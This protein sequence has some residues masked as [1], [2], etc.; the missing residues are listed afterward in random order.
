MCTVSLLVPQEQRIAAEQPRTVSI[1]RAAS[2]VIPHQEICSG[3]D[4]G[5]RLST[6]GAPDASVVGEMRGEYLCSAVHAVTYPS[7]SGT[8]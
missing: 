8:A 3:S 5:E 6:R 1:I 4:I 2:S 7:T